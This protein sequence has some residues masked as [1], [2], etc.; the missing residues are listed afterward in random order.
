M[1]RHW[2]LRVEDILDAMALVESFTKD[3]KLS[4]FRKDVRTRHAVIH[5]LQVIGE[6][7]RHIPEAIKRKHIHIPWRKIVGLRNVLVHQ[8]FGTDIRIVWRTA[9][10]VL[11]TLKSD[12]RS[13]LDTDLADDG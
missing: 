8:Y 2:R 4:G 13:M 12:F 11:R 1:P 6:S 10:K 3:L 5:N 9:T 7:A